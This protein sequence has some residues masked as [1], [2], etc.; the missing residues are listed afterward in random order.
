MSSR[1]QGFGVVPAAGPSSWSWC[2]RWC[3]SGPAYT[4]SRGGTGN[5]TAA[6][7]SRHAASRR[8]EALAPWPARRRPRGPSRRSRTSG[9]RGPDPARSRG[10]APRGAGLVQAWPLLSMSAADGGPG[11]S[12]E[13]PSSLPGPLYREGPLGRH[14]IFIHPATPQ[15]AA[16]QFCPHHEG[17]CPPPSHRGGRSGPRSHI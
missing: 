6:Y 16:K 2:S 17:A 12:L 4:W 8:G 9:R 5:S 10:F 3:G 13:N 14:R 7:R 1:R 15:R 11:S